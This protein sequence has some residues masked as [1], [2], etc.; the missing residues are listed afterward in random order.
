MAFESY[1]V[2]EL[3]EPL[4]IIDSP[5][6]DTTSISEQKNIQSSEIFNVD[7]LRSYFVKRS[8][9]SYKTRVM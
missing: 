8:R 2:Q 5:R 4:C 3:R 9:Q 6:E 1:C 7:E